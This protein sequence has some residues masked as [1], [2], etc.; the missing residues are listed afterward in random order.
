MDVGAGF[1][2]THEQGLAGGSGLSEAVHWRCA[3]GRHLV[4]DQSPDLGGI[5]DLCP[6][7]VAAPMAGEDVRTVGDAHLMG[8]GKHSKECA[9]HAGAGPNNR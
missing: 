8:I 3:D 1:G 4:V 9:G 5:F 2:G 6:L 7:V